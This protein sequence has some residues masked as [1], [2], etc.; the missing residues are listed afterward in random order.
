MAINKLIFT[1]YVDPNIARGPDSN[2][3]INLIVWS[4]FDNKFGRS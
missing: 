4:N 2:Y 3:L 1:N